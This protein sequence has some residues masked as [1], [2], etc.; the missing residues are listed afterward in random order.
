[1]LNKME[2]WN[3]SLDLKMILP[4][5]VWILSYWCL[6][7]SES[8]LKFC[9]LLFLLIVVYDADDTEGGRPENAESS[10]EQGKQPFS[11]TNPVDKFSCVTWQMSNVFVENW[12]IFINSV[13]VNRGEWLWSPVNFKG[14]NKDDTSSVGGSTAVHNLLFFAQNTMHKLRNQNVSIG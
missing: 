1:M 13:I 9:N 6:N 8:I 3:P 14:A 4:E 12:T 7:P 2:I 11:A 10:S 5:I